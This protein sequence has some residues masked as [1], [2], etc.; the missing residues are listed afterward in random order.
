MLTMLPVADHLGLSCDAGCT[1]VQIEKAHPI[2]P[3]N[4]EKK[5]ARQAPAMLEAMARQPKAANVAKAAPGPKAP[6]AR[7][8]APPKLHNLAT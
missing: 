4:E 8:L 1:R 3:K 5:K 7:K 6:A 2:V